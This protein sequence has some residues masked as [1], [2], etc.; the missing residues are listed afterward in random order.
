M[1]ETKFELGFPNY[2][3]KSDLKIETGIDTSEFVKKADLDS[4]N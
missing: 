3:T 1:G 4:L 2:A